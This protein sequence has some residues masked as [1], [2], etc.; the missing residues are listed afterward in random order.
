MKKMVILNHNLGRLANQLWQYVSVYAYALE[1]GFEVENLAFFEYRKFYPN[2]P[3]SRLSSVLEPL[4]AFS[5]KLSPKYGRYITYA[6][7]A[8]FAKLLQS[9]PSRNT[10]YITDWTFRSPANTRRHRKEICRL[11]TPDN[12][13]TA[14][15]ENEIQVLRKKYDK[16]VGVHIR[17]GDYQTENWKRLLFTD[18]RVSRILDQYLEFVKLPAIKVCFLICSDGKTEPGAYGNKRVVLSRGNAIEDL[19]KLSLTDA[20]IGSD[21]TF[22]AF[23]SF[24]GDK[25]YIVLDDKTDWTYYRDKTGYFENKFNTTV[26][27]QGKR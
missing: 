3:P 21:S 13:I 24:Y 6:L 11:F 18:A 27:Y 19:Y 15:N 2:L 14:R 12:T 10:E 9:L 25:P 17:R 16:V 1:N 8:P 23:A 7:I 4:N 5:C 22:G 20:I 26:N